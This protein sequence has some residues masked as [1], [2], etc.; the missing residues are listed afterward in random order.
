MNLGIIHVAF[1]ALEYP[2]LIL[3]SC[4]SSPQAPDA[5]CHANLSQSIPKRD[6]PTLRP[7]SESI[8]SSNRQ[9]CSP[10]VGQLQQEHDH[11]KV[12]LNFPRPLGQRP[13]FRVTGGANPVV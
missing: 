3:A 13:V 11:H 7:I 8:T 12:S 10:P 9:S 5:I 4:F 6:T 1:F 2:R